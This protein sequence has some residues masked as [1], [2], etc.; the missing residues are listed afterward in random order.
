MDLYKLLEIMKRQ[1]L[2]YVISRS[3]TATGDVP[4]TLVGVC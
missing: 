3:A 4:H 1:V 2:D